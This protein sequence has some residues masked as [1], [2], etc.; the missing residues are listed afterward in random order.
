MLV[1]SKVATLA[2]LFHV[3]PGAVPPGVALPASQGDFFLSIAGREGYAKASAILL[4]A[5][6]E[7]G[8]AMVKQYAVRSSAL[9]EDSASRSFAGQYDTVLGLAS[10]QDIMSAIEACVRSATSARVA[11]YRRAA[12]AGPAWSLGVLIQEMIPADRAGVAFTVNPLTGGREVI[13]NASFGLGDLLVSG[14][15]TPDQIIIDDSGRAPRVTVGSKRMMSILTQ[16]G[17][18]RTSVPR[19]L[20][21]APCLSDGQV[22]A[23]V[24]AARACEVALGYPV[25]VEW[26]LSSETLFVL[27][28]RPITGN[29]LGRNRLT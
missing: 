21:R 13:I 16:H 23:V 9:E 2:R 29:I 3:L 15:I 24:A 26:A 12:G 27:Q 14:E 7:R 28:A 1:G 17:V 8:R 11:A 19:S 22:N 18:I 4:T 5:L 20:Q 10:A 25:D 6:G